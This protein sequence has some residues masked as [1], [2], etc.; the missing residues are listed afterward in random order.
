[1]EAGNIWFWPFEEEFIVWLQHL[2]EGTFLQS[3]L[4]VLGNFFSFLGEETICIAVMGFLY[5]G[6]NKEK[7]ERIGASIMFANL[8]IGLLKNI[9]TR[10]RPWATSER[11]NLLRNVDGYSFPSGHSANSTALYPT[12]AYEY[13]KS[14]ILRWIA[15]CVPLLVGVSRCYVGAHWPTDVLVG[16][17]VGLIVFIG[18]EIILHKIRNKYVF[19]LIVAAISGVGF[20][21]CRTNDYY[22]SI[23]MLIGFIL[24]IRFEEK[25]V[26]FENTKN[27]WIA[28]LR[29]VIGGALY[30]AISAVL[31]LL[32]G[33][34]FPEGTTGY[35]LMRSLRYG[36]IVFLLV[37]VYPMAFRLEKKFLKARK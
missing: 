4:L 1:M 27:I 13:K 11:I 31:K 19:Y 20:Y 6:I 36:M 2:G 33:N 32:I 5:W 16:W 8:S 30:F 22:N 14:K 21:Y 9:F 35:L 24:A 34:I 37:G 28:L 23:G 3:V 29:T 10:L 15:V 7:G 26:R 18:T 25:K 17:C 12:V